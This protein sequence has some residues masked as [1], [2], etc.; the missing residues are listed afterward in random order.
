MKNYDIAVIGAGL[1]GS[2][3]TLK[4]ANLGYDVV[5]VAPA[6]GR[7]DG[8]TTALMAPSIS[9]L[10]TMGLWDGIKAQSA[11]LSTMQIIDGTER[12][13][14]S[15]PV[16]FRAAEL[17]L[18]AFGYNIPNAPFLA[19][20]DDAL[21]AA[22]LVTLVDG[23]MTAI[24]ASGGEREIMTETGE[25]FR[26]QLVVGADGRRSAVREAAGIEARTWSYP[27]TALV[28]TFEHSRPHHDTSTEFHTGSGPFTQ[29]PLPGNRSSL[30]W[31]CRPQDAEHY[32]SLSIDGLSREVEARMQSMLGAVHVDS[33]VQTYPLSG[34]T[35]LQSGKGQVVLIGEAAH[36]FPPIGAQGLNLSLRDIQTLA[37][38]LG[39]KAETPI[40]G[41]TGERFNR[42]RKLDIVTRTVGVDLLNRSLLSDFL[43]VQV[44]RAA[45]LQALS[46]TAPLRA[47]MMQEGMAPGSSFSNLASSLREKI[48]WKR[49]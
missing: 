13:I 11:P 20:L 37:D 10:E 3:A 42:R 27:Q 12:L 9:I 4:L 8:R 46:A 31:V 16:N 36:A 21:K 1:A 22:P 43:P 48:G 47:F 41:S 45:G 49:A 44:L 24:T 19:L 33:A 38:L 35:A 7:A 26:V 14:R 34:M 29:V 25:V 28:L 5:Q 18:D 2:I 39:P 15:P 17:G 32:R 6:A 30:V 23:R 40:D